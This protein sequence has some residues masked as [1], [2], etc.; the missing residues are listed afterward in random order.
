MVLNVFINLD[1][2]LLILDFGHSLGWTSEN[3][4][5]N[6]LIKCS[7]GKWDNFE[8]YQKTS[9]NPISV[10]TCLT[11]SCMSLRCPTPHRYRYWPWLGK[12]LADHLI[13]QL[14]WNLQHFSPLPLSL[15][16]FSIKP[17][18]RNPPAAGPSVLLKMVLIAN[19]GD[20]KNNAT[21]TILTVCGRSN[22]NR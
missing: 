15:S 18:P 14:H 5:T 16:A 6:Q 13:R 12:L 21:E 10:S 11:K 22:T 20:R 17:G 19:L 8:V 3:E 7:R 2:N 9:Q 4:N 1:T